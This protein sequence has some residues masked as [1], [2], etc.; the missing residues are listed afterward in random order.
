MS[1]TTVKIP[2][3]I[4][5]DDPDTLVSPSA[6]R[7]EWKGELV[8]ARCG[9][10]CP[11]CGRPLV[12]AR[13]RTDDPHTDYYFKHAGLDSIACDGYSRQ[14]IKKIA[15]QGLTRGDKILLPFVRLEDERPHA[16]IP[17]R[18]LPQ[19]NADDNAEDV[20]RD[21]SPAK[22][23][24][25][26]IGISR[27]DIEYATVMF[28]SVL[29]E[30]G[31]EETLA[32]HLRQNKPLELT[33]I[34]ELRDKGYPCLEVE[35]G[36]IA[37]KMFSDA[38]L[39]QVVKRLKGGV[40]RRST[41]KQ[42]LY[43]PAVARLL[44]ECRKLRGTRMTLPPFH[45]SSA[46]ASPP[47]SQWTGSIKETFVPMS[48]GYR[49]PDMIVE[50][51]PNAVLET[52][53]PLDGGGYLMTA[54]GD[55]AVRRFQVV[56]SDSPPNAAQLPEEGA[57]LLILP[58]LP[59]DT[60]CDL[61]DDLVR[62]LKQGR[63]LRNAAVKDKADEM[64]SLVV[65]ADTTV[66]STERLWENTSEDLGVAVADG[67]GKF[68][69]GFVDL[70]CGNQIVQ[71]DFSI[72]IEQAPIISGND[73]LYCLGDL[74]EQAHDMLLEELKII[75]EGADDPYEIVSSGWGY[76]NAQSTKERMGALTAIESRLA[77]ERCVRKRLSSNRG[78]AATEVDMFKF[79]DNDADA[80]AGI[81]VTRRRLAIDVLGDAVRRSAYREKL[82]S[83]GW[84]NLECDENDRSNKVWKI[85]SDGR[86]TPCFVILIVNDEPA[87]E[88][89]LGRIGMLMM[90]LASLWKKEREWL[91]VSEYEKDKVPVGKMAGDEHPRHV[92]KVQLDWKNRR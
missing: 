28:V 18:Y 77:Y 49:L 76:S 31:M 79:V 32:V 24:L 36:S 2:Y 16:S 61:P 1:S 53:E 66:L 64:Y 92:S 86:G 50:E 57:P 47:S 15:S 81:N 90:D 34:E 17:E 13:Y 46:S 55:G 12:A 52:I 85:L 44:A 19:R 60:R 35:I 54:D 51:H 84:G 68:P 41:F 42:W 63:W 27:E 25:L 22:A 43:Y 20:L 9:L 29:W 58:Q 6:R 4:L 78:A 48:N 30:N 21:L 10:V 75:N 73:S 56:F 37:A 91:D 65:N 67:K 83:K 89:L 7:K 80:L 71:I 74:P 8:G 72:S 69:G 87:E 45:L 82:R 70:L 40:S 3:G 26:D 33:A 62:S 23:T 5:P 88:N 38:W 59:S 14:T 39:S 11:E